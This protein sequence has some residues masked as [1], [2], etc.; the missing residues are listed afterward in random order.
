MALQEEHNDLLGLLAQQ[1]LELQI[2]RDSLEHNAGVQFVLTAD[3]QVEQQALERYGAYINFRRGD[4]DM[5]GNEGLFDDE[6]DGYY[7]EVV[8]EDIASSGQ[9]KYIRRDDRDVVGVDSNYGL[10]HH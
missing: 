4:Y 7:D 5:D 2:F 9:Y 1:E 8:A 3:L 6:N 10:H